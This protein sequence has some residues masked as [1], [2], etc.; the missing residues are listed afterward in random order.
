[1]AAPKVDPSI[2]AH[3]EWLKFVQPTGLV[4]SAPALARAGA[5]LDRNDA[6][7]QRLLRACVEERVLSGNE[8]PVPLLPDFS[9]FARTVLGWTFSPKGYAGTAENPIPPD[10]EAALPESEGV[11]R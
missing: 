9:A 7:G 10:L 2:L 6:E 1:M 5:I 11:L 8:K 4:V 3:R